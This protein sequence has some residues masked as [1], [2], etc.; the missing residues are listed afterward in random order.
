MR[1]QSQKRYCTEVAYCVS[2]FE[3]DSSE[4][5]AAYS[6]NQLGSLPFGNYAYPGD[7]SAACR[8]PRVVMARE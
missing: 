4:I 5:S 6:I 7:F 3:V 1:L 8:H 2:R